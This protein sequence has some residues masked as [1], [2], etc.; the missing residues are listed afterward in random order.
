[1]AALFFDVDGTLLDSYHGISSVTPAVRSELAR[2]QAQGHK[3]F[4][5][6]GRPRL[7][8]TDDLLDVGWDGLVLVNGGYVEMGGQS[9]HEERM[10][11]ELAQSV[12]DFLDDMDEPYLVACARAI[13]T[14]PTNDDIRDFF[15]RGHGNIFTFDFDL[16]EVLPQAIKM[17]TLVPREDRPR[18]TAKIMDAFDGLISCDGHGGEGTFELYPTAISKAKGIQVVLDRLGLS[19]ADAY[20]FGDGTNDL[21]MI[22]YCGCGVAMGNAEDEVKAGA[23]MV[24][25]PVW[26]DGVAQVLR[27]LF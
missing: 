12:V 3:I 10:G 21:E 20:A 1:M 6:S 15:A 4:L 17:E 8:I 16:N 19:R 9:V 24:C 7:L 13:Y 27:E 2:V 18:M 26:E 5:S 22:R 14:L 11:V 23:D 25:A